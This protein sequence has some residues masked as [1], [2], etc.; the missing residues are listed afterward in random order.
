MKS[1]VVSQATATRERLFTLI[2]RV[3]F[4]PSVSSFVDSQGTILRERLFTLITRVWFR[5]CVNSFVPNQVTII[6]KKTF[7]ID[8][9]CMVSHMCEYFCVWLTQSRI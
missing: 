1:F 5:T 8:H 6:R 9:N 2:T 3:W 4:L 7:H